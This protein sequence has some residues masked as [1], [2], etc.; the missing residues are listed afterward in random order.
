MSSRGGR[1][2]LTVRAALAAAVVAAAPVFC[3]P[4]I[5]LAGQSRA[6]AGPPPARNSC[7]GW[8]TSRFWEAAQAATVRECLVRGYRVGARSSVGN[9]TPLHW[10]AG[11]SDDPDVIRVLVEA[12]ADLE[13]SSRPVDRTPLHY[14]ARYNDNVDVLRAVLAYEPNLYAV[15]GLGRTPLHLAAL[16]NDNPAIVEELARA[17]QV[18]V[19]AVEGNTPLHDAARRLRDSPFTGAPNPAVAEVLLRRGADV[20]A[21]TVWGYTP[22][23]GAED[24]RVADLIREERARREA[25]RQRFFEHVTT[26][27]A[28]GALVLGVLGHL[29]M[30]WKRARRLRDS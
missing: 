30:L 8:T 1:R 16:F 23:A 4:G 28:L 11:Y 7:D 26:S 24:R 14:A 18:N 27:V 6:G 12:G 19:K 15:N 5:P 29:S 20:S 9:E 10:A 25:L 3:V 13:D 2:L 22:E 21:E 17:T